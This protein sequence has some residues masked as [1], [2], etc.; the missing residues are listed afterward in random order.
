MNALQDVKGW[1]SWWGWTNDGEPG[2]VKK[3][4]DGNVIGRHGDPLWQRDVEYACY[5]SQKRHDEQALIDEI[6]R[7]QGGQDHA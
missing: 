6:E 2:S 7:S 3:D 4:A 1:M 5:K